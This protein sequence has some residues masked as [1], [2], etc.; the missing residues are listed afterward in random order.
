M[1]YATNLRLQVVMMNQRVT[2]TLKRQIATVLAPMQKMD[3]IA[4]ETAWLIP[5]VMAFAIHSKSRD[6]RT[7]P[8]V[9]TIPAPQTMT[10][11]VRTLL[12]VTIVTGIA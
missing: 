1:A 4:T 8:P 2:T 11:L 9:T 10:I 6:V 5:T 12:T 3:M 7:K